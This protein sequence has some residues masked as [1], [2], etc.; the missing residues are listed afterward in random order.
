MIGSLRD[1]ACGASK[2]HSGVT[3]THS[4]LEED[5]PQ[6]HLV[7]DETIQSEL[8]RHTCGLRW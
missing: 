8:I 1:A 7:N 2:G 3:A 5:T 4:P 6:L